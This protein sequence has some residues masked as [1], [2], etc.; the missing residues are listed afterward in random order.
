MIFGSDY[1]DT[2]G[3][4]MAD[5]NGFYDEKAKKSIDVDYH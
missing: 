2:K 5:N 1:I 4:N 3:V